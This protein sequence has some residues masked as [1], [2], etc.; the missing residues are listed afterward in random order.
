M[1]F[2]I[3]DGVIS[4]FGLSVESAEFRE[5]L[6]L[7]RKRDNLQLAGLQLHYASGSLATLE[8]RVKGMLELIRAYD[9][10]P[11]QVDLGGGHMG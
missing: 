5:V 4:P 3:N 8:P 11:V 6:E 10:Q 9:L 1:N 7:I 2:A